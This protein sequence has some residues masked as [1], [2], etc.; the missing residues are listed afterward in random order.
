MDARNISVVVQ[1]PL[2]Q[3][4]PEGPVHRQA[5]RVLAS[6]R[7]H[8]PGS[9]LILSTWRGS[10]CQGLDCDILVENED[11]GTIHFPPVAEMRNLKR[12]IVST[13]NGISRASRPFLL[14]LR[15]DTMLHG[16]GFT[17]FWGL[18]PAR[19]EAYRF[20]K[21]RVVNCNIVAQSPHRHPGA[22]PHPSDWAFFGRREDVAAL[23]DTP[24]PDPED[25]LRRHGASSAPS[26]T[27]EGY[28]WGEF[29][30]RFL[31]SLDY[32][33]C[34][35]ETVA[36][37]EHAMVNNFALVT[38]RQFQLESLKYPYRDASRLGREFNSYTVNEWK[39]LYNRHCGG[40]LT[41]QPAWVD[42]RNA[43]IQF[44]LK[45]GEGRFP[46]AGRALRRLLQRLTLPRPGG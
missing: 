30:R 23:L 22:L 36:T 39:R 43:L 46:Y 40:D 41:I 6:V 42:L 24:L 7:L 33:T 10:D 27:P 1:G 38:L 11:P 18:H 8:L 28:I 32:I 12:L 19:S 14:K 31:P 9:E 2:D 20:L 34:C 45:H 5:A 15:T 26:M 4:P 37:L 25:L 44:H 35:E 17:R 29:L 13:R 16:D 3:V 21:D